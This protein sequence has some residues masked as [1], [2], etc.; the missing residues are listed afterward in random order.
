MAIL[1]SAK[2]RY[3]L[4]MIHVSVIQKLFIRTMD[5]TSADFYYNSSVFHFILNYSKI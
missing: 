2:I 3:F 5:D 4:M 1:I